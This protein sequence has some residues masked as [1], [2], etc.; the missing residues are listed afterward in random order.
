MEKN[1]SSRVQISAVNPPPHGKSILPLRQSLGLSGSIVI[2]AGTVGLLGVFAFLTFLWVGYGSKSEAANATWA[3][4][5]IALRGYMEQVITLA[6][7]VLT[8]IVS[9][10]AAVCTSMAAALILEKWSVPKA[11]V[12]SYSTSFLSRLSCFVTVSKD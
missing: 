1:A 2:V 5:Q 11:K 12:S 4:R 9:L 3:W 8:F 7:L 10:Q 6:A